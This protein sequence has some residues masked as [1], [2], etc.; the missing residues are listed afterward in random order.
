M[1]TDAGE[2]VVKIT[3]QIDNFMDGLKTV[4]TKVV[5]ATKDFSKNYT[6]IA[7][8]AAA[9]GAA[10]FAFAKKS[11]EAYGEQELALTRL[12]IAVGK[13]SAAALSE[14]AGALQKTTTFSDEAIMSL[15]TQLSNFGLMPG[16]IKAA[17]A[18]LLDF[19][20]ATGKS[21]PEAGQIFGQAMAGQ[22]RELKKYGLILEDTDTKSDRLQKVTKLLTE[23]FNG[24]AEAIKGTALGSME[25]LANQIS[26]LEEKIGKF[27]LPVLSTWVKLIGSAV[28]GMNK[29][30][31]AQSNEM[32]VREI[33]IAQLKRES[34]ILK[35]ALQGN[36]EYRAEAEKI[37][38]VQK[39]QNAAM[40]HRLTL[41]TKVMAS[42]KTQI[43]EEKK[44]ATQKTGIIDE[45]VNK[46]TQAFRAGADAENLARDATVQH[47]LT[48]AIIKVQSANDTARAEIYVAQQSFQAQADFSTQLHV[49]LEQDISQTKARFV[50]MAVSAA[51]SLG[52]GVADMIMNGKKFSDV[53]KAIWQDM[54]RQ[55]IAQVTAM[56]AKWLILQAL[57]GGSGGIGRI[58]GGFASG[59]MINEP[60]VITG[61]RSGR[62]HFVAEGG[63]EMIV[64]AG[65]GGGAYNQPFDGSGGG[66]GGGNGDVHV[67]ITGQF[68]EGNPAKWQKFIRS[69]VVPEIRRWTT[70]SPTGPFERRR[71]M[72]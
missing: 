39:D 12:N 22:S 58:F 10:I 52:N 4:N 7:V 31:G 26:E 66:G 72:A 44:A 27:L 21:L 15:E 64:P 51:D 43:T 37:V 46:E 47:V 17:T 35:L 2:L 25:N 33:Q 6:G 38:G 20:A 24:T 3:A 18:P 50:D 67:H 11:V 41:V 62:S 57:T 5:E 61:M 30:A 48:G 1:A 53:M 36:S 40:T 55:F 63:P 14:Y 65:G 28:D 45:E 68:L 69:T 42:L 8:G 70:S 56:I 19:A 23:K 49:K 54:A 9:A 71:G 29:L 60:S 34:E 13:E 16:S 32:S 59:G